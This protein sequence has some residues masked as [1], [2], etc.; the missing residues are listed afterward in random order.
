MG[1]EALHAFLRRH[2]RLALDTSTFIY[3]AEQNPRYADLAFHVFNWLETPQN[4]AVTSTVT[5][6]ELLVQAYREDD[7][8]RADKVVGMFGA[9]PNLLWIPA[10]LDVADLAARMRALYRMR[11]PDALQAATAIYAGATGLV[12]NDPIFKR[13]EKIEVAVLDEFV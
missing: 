11:T 10:D 12:T 2:S 6:T 8:D 4:Q 1:V 5:M 13:L 3:Q 9:Y 7:T